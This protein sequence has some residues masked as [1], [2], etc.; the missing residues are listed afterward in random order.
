MIKKS[1]ACL[2]VVS[3]LLIGQASV[4]SLAQTLPVLERVQYHHPGLVVDL[5][6]GL[7]AQPLP[8]DYDGDGD[9]DLLVAT[10]DKPYNGLYFFENRDPNSRHPVFEPAVRI[11]QGLD[12]VTVS[13]DGIVPIVTSPGK[14]YP[15]IKQ[16]GLTQSKKIPFKGDVHIPEGRIRSNQWSYV[17]FN[18]NGVLDL[19]VGVGDYKDHVSNK[20]GYVYYIENKGTDEKPKY[21]IPIKLQAGGDPVNVYGQ[22]SP[23]FADFNG[24]GKMDMITGEF[25]DKFTFFENTGTRAQPVY[26][27]G[28]H[29]RTHNNELLRMDLQMLRVTAIDWTK[30]GH[31]D[32]IVGQEDGRAA[33]I[34][35]T[36]KV[37]NGMPIFHDPYFFKQKADNLKVGVLSTPFSFDWNGDG[38]DDL[39][40]GDSSGRI[41]YIENADGMNPPRWKAPV[42]L[43]AS[44]AIIRIQPGN[45]GGPEEEKWGYTTIA[46][47]D[48]NHDGL[49]DLMGNSITGE[50]QWYENI[51]SRSTPKLKAAQP[52]EVQWHSTSPKP[53]WIHW[54][55]EG[56]SLVTQWRTNPY[57]IDLNEDG[58]NDLIMLDHDGYL[59]FFERKKNAGKLQLL[60]GKR[61]FIGEEGSS[62]FD[63]H[64]NA[65]HAP[66]GPIRMNT[67]TKGGSGRRK[68]T[69]VDWNMDGKLDIVVNGRPNV[70]L[71]LNIGTASEPYVY[72]DM[73]SMAEGLLAGHSTA[74]TVVDWDKNGAPDLLIGA[75][76]GHFYHLRNDFKPFV[77]V[78]SNV[79]EI[80][81]L[82]R[83]GILTGYED[84]LFKPNQSITRLEAVTVILRALKQELTQYQ[85]PSVPFTDVV[86]EDVGYQTIANAYERGYING[87]LD[88]ST[89]NTHFEANGILTRGEMAK[90][91][92]LAFNLEIQALK[93]SYK[94]FKDV[95]VSDWYYPYIRALA[96]HKITIGFADATFRPLHPISRAHFALFLARILNE[97]YTQ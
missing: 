75:E 58:L 28:R 45:K 81:Y 69:M 2:L 87:K 31:V 5:G 43:K 10:K 67:E 13:Y 71:L 27:A 92:T 96:S 36:G 17:D 60:P 82:K 73:G 35:H 12:N 97:N 66:R 62:K 48:W 25:L 57:I 33:L 72:K 23:V 50:V 79:G 63:R 89:G 90:M 19:I 3:T 55:P 16:T 38:K 49:P 80:Q 77:D 78:S 86:P 21:G 70:K 26:K 22:P 34:E 83:Q 32:L 52:V 56:L 91:L 24:D 15:H 84:G 6:V 94:G 54:E 7:E 68:F 85:P 93:Q 9:Y 18:G 46:V 11:S 20:L 41:S 76:D 4:S 53:D 47:A 29:L 1:V 65:T 37:L 61:I 44:G 42:P 59:A 14:V 95:A 40:V 51:G 64:G 88:L 39:I 8:M 74:P 30:D